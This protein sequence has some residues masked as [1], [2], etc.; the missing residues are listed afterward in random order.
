MAVATELRIAKLI[1]EDARQLHSR[2]SGAD[3]PDISWFVVCVDGLSKVEEVQSCGGLWVY[4]ILG[5]QDLD[6]I[7]Q[8]IGYSQEHNCLP[9]G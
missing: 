9:C 1:E 6:V 7:L 5:L 8:T 4:W 2:A 3:W